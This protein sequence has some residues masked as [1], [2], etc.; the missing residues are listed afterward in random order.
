M[1]DLTRLSLVPV[2][3]EIITIGVVATLATDFWQRFLQAIGLP[4]AN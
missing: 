4:P 2:A 1:V 3:E